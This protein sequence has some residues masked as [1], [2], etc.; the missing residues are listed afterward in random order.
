MVKSFQSTSTHS[1]KISRDLERPNAP[2]VER[3][4]NSLDDAATAIMVKKIDGHPH[5]Q[6]LSE[7]I[8]LL[9]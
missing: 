1:R 2:V 6:A 5:H 8:H 4:A 7:I 3:L 9:N